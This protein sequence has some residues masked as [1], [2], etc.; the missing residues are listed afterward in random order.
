MSAPRSVLTIA[1][2][3]SALFLALIPAGAGAYANVGPPT[4]ASPSSGLP[5]GRVYELASPF[6][7]HGFEVGESGL[8]SG[9]KSPIFSIASADGDAVSFEAKGPAG[10]VDSGGLSEN[11]VAERTPNGWKSRSSTARGLHQNE[12]VSLLR[13]TPFW[14]DYSPDLSHLAYSVVGPA[15]AGPIQGYWNF[16]LLGAEPLAE[17]AWLLRDA[18]QNTPSTGEFPGTQL[19]GMSPDA[20]I[21]YIA[22]EA[23]LLPED[24]SRSGWGLYEY[25]NG[26][27]SEAGVLPDG[28]VPA[29]GALP[30]STNP[31]PRIQ[32]AGPGLGD[33]ASLDN[34]VSEDGKRVFY[35]SSGEI[36]VHKIE[37][38]GS[39]RT[40]LVSASQLPGHAGE[41]AP[42]GAVP[43]ENLTKQSGAEGLGPEPTY[44]Y[45]SPDGTHV[46]FQSV[47]QLTEAAPTGGGPKVYDFNVD[48]GSLEYLPAVTLGGI[49]TTASDGSSFVFMNRANPTPELDLWSAGTDGGKVSQIVQLPGGG[50]VGPGRMVADNSVFVFQAQAPVVGFNNVGSEQIY[51]YDIDRNELDCISCPPVGI[52]PSG[53]AYLSPEDQ[54]SP[55][56]GNPETGMVNDARGVSISGGQVFFESPDPLVG[57]DT[58]GEPDAYEWE[59]GTVYLLSS[60]TS[61]EP[62]WFLDNGQSGG[63]VFF[64][65]SD[66]LVAG[67]TD[68][69]YDVY[70]ARIPRP[71]DNPPPSAAPCNGASCQGPPSVAQ[72]LGAPS[73]STFDGVGNVV[74]ELPASKAKSTPKK[75]S[76]AQKLASALR[77]CHQR[78]SKTKRVLCE[79]Q[80]RKRYSAAGASAKHNVGRGK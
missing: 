33:P 12:E 31:T 48:V 75:L 69:G 47:D 66:E 23:R 45:A 78:R 80:T 59:D 76:R 22:D 53:D 58:N 25:R 21:V 27:L 71:G 36:Y 16:Y 14:R 49:V 68:G 17:P 72:L 29:S 51:R 41:A 1:F 42:D 10:E 79:R 50:Y 57:R 8:G 64:T 62:S 77:V 18:I 56:G 20:S 9:D 55:V 39:E 63:D 19:L 70:D 35:R 43:F 7:K 34:G 37:P 73:S 2:T 11:F 5:D 40:T 30:L 67:D 46:F 6:N 61:P 38:D 28:S 26:V 32:G 65:S 24:S 15:V 3:L 4:S 60:G 54:Y 74:G 52:Q 13:Q 44:A